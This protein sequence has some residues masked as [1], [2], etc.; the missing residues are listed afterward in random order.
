MTN[1][2]ALYKPTNTLVELVDKPYKQG[3]QTYIAVKACS[4]KP[5]ADGAKTTTQTA[6]KT[7]NVKDLKINKTGSTLLDRALTFQ[8]KRQWAA[9]E[10][11]WLH[12]Q[13]FLKEQMG[14]IDLCL[15]DKRVELHVYQFNP[16]A[17]RWQT[18]ENLQTKYQAWTER[19]TK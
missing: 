17:G 8:N 7:V 13:A 6:Y 9:G 10:S 5:W 14:V 19:V 4:G 1:Y 2:T 16:N 15:V 3:D 12:P 11:I 18:C